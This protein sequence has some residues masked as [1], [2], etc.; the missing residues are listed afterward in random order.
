MEIFMG[1]LNY[2]DIKSETIFCWNLMTNDTILLNYLMKDKI[3]KYLN[4]ND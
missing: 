2:V 4:N 1:E 3:G